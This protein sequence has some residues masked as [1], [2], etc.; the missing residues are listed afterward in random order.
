MSPWKEEKEA[1]RRPSSQ[2]DTRRSEGSVWTGCTYEER[3]NNQGGKAVESVSICHHLEGALSRSPGLPSRPAL[4]W[5]K[6]GGG[7]LPSLA[8]T[9]LP[10]AMYVLRLLHSNSLKQSWLKGDR[11]DTDLTLG[12]TINK[13]G[14]YCPYSKVY[15]CVIYIVA[16]M[17]VEDM[18][19][20]S[21]TSG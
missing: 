17:N 6:K 8:W 5:T 19:D 16:A 13:E 2:E 3:P 20:G 9:A 14:S 12:D 21:T 11:V 15:D 7:F 1:C 4:A 18:H 10:P